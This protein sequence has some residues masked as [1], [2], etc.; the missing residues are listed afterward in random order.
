[1][2]LRKFIAGQSLGMSV[3]VAVVSNLSDATRCLRADEANIIGDHRLAYL[4]EPD[5]DYQPSETTV[6][7]PDARA[8]AAGQN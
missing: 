2:T 3:L 1:M 7:Q 4:S 8:F 5:R 6:P